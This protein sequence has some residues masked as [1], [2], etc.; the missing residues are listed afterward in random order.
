MTTSYAS[1]KANRHWISS[2]PSTVFGFSLVTSGG[3]LI[4]D[5]ALP[6]PIFNF[7]SIASAHS[8]TKCRPVTHQCNRFLPPN[9]QAQFPNYFGHKDAREASVSFQKF[10]GILRNADKDCSATLSTFLCGLHVPPC[11]K[12]KRP[13][14]PCREFCLKARSQCKR[15]MRLSKRG[16]LQWPSILKCRNFP[17][18]DEEPCYNGQ[19]IPEPTTKPQPTVPGNEYTSNPDLIFNSQ[20]LIFNSPL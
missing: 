17:G 15:E 1:I 13:L 9:W 16:G 12:T 20:D 3:G 7:L 19:I 18:K 14:L 4:I 11:R 2:L 8:A 6:L 10:E 5:I